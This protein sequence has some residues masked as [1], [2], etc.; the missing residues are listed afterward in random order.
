M[1]DQRR[2]S[3]L[4]TVEQKSPTSELQRVPIAPRDSLDSRVPATTTPTSTQKGETKTPAAENSTRANTSSSPS[5]ITSMQVERLSGPLQIEFVQPLDSIVVRGKQRD[6]ERVVGPPTNVNVKPAATKHAQPESDE[7]TRLSRTK[8]FFYV[9]D[10]DAAAAEAAKDSI[11]EAAK[12][13]AT[14]KSAPKNESPAADAPSSGTTRLNIRID[15]KGNIVS[16]NPGAA[17]PESPAVDD[18]NKGGDKASIPGAP[19]VV[20]IGASGVLIASEDKDALNEFERLMSTL[21]SPSIVGTREYTVFYLKHAKAATAAVLLQQMIGG[22]TVSSGGG[23]GI[24]GDI[25]QQAIGGFGGGFLGGLLGGGQNQNNS[26]VPEGVV[27]GARGTGGPVDIIPDSRL[28]ALIVQASPSDVDTI[29]QLLHVI[30]QP[31]SPEEVALVPKPR[32]IYVNNTTADS[33]ADVVKQVYSTRLEGAAAGGQ[34][35]F[36]PAMLFQQALRGGRGGRGGQQQEEP[37]KMSI[38]VDERNNALVVA[39]PDPLFHEVEDLVAKLDQESAGD[40]VTTSIVHVSSTSGDAMKTALLAVL[41]DQAKSSTTSPTTGQNRP[42]TSVAQNQGGLG[43]QFGGNPAFRQQMGLINALQGGGGGPGGFG[44]GP[45]GGGGF[46]RGG[47]GGGGPGGGGG[48]FGGRGGG[49]GFGTGGGGGGFGG[50]GGGGGGGG[51]R[52]GGGG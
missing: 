15:E 50:R 36:N 2:P 18:K 7:S 9:A 38:G 28:N 31:D 26:I 10:T 45:G 27:T 35:Q 12:K 41:G 44:G 20:V 19:I 1:I 24:V 5:S 14:Q 52:R 6:V 39:A 47:F 3:Q 22:G 4:P 51:G 8:R 34:N 32:L 16:N 40:K 33:V 48:G 17:A 46:N 25:A 49:G 37:S 21:T 29:D 43:Q 42:N 23:G 30:D 13:S 11:T